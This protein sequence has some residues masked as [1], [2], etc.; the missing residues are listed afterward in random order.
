MSNGS[1]L[2]PN[3]FSQH[4]V[5]SIGYAS[6]AIVSTVVF[7]RLTLLCVRPRRLTSEEYLVLIAYVLFVAQCSLYV[8]I[9]PIQSRILDVQRGKEP[10]YEELVNDALL[11]GKLYNPALWMFW[12]ILW[13]IKGSFLMLYRH[14]VI[15]LPVIYERVWWAMVS[16]CIIVSIK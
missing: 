4:T 1:K 12:M 2:P 5:S 13:L 16:F 11:L 14:M 8:V 7:A 15:R 3:A 9:A 10:Y 6:I